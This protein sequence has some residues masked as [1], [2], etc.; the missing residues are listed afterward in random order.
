[1]VAANRGQPGTR[2]QPS[3]KRTRKTKLPL[4]LRLSG[5]KRYKPTFHSV[6]PMSDPLPF[7]NS[8]LNKAG[9]LLQQLSAANRLPPSDEEVSKARE[10]VQYYREAHTRALLGARMGLQSCIKSEGVRVVV[11]AQRLKRLPT[12][13]DK[14]Q[15][16]PTMKLSTM[17]DI[18]GCRAVLPT[19]ADIEVVQQRFMLN[20]ERRGRREGASVA[21][22]LVDGPRQTG[23]RAVH[24]IT[25]YAGRRVEVQL[26]TA[27]QHIWAEMVERLS[28]A[29]GIGFKDGQ[30]P[31]KSLDLL[32]NLAELMAAVDC[33]IDAETAID[34]YSRYASGQ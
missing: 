4:A 34:Y 18:A 23:Y 15:R 8:Q 14:L 7:S 28:D 31:S 25:Y 33:T 5:G 30:G 11:L 22:K 17:Q 3:C 9:K 1:M 12:I 24:I 10:I 32:C 29:S 13:V 26:R 2:S 6:R 16:H 19:R 27:L 20:S 21:D